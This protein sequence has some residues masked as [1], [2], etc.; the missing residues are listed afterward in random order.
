MGLGAYLFFGSRDKAGIVVPAVKEKRAEEISN[1]SSDWSIE[2]LSLRT[3]QSKITI[4]R[5]TRETA[6]FNSYVV[7]FDSDGLKQFA[8]MNVPKSGKPDGGF[9]VVVVNH[10]YIPPEEFSVEN[11]YINTSA[12]YANNGFLVLKPDYR[13]HDNSEGTATGLR[14]RI[15]YSIDV[16]N[17]IAG[18]KSLENADFENIF[19]FGHSMGGEVS[20]RVGEICGTCIR[21]ISFWAPAVTSWPESSFYFS[22]RNDSARFERLQNEFR[23]NFS[24]AD[25]ATVSTWENINRLKVPVIVHH[26][27]ADESVPYSWGV[28]LDK[29]FKSEGVSSSLYTYQNDNHDIAANW[30]RALNRDIEFF[31]RT[32]E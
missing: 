1:K 24:E 16:L 3:Y 10:G 20:L 23:E 19:M 28:E 8:L 31:R 4:E 32:I 5:K 18:I 12:Y 29:K 15:S 26:G 13:G 21:A 14:D 7:S 9:P 30:S 2:K 17:L 6:L 27:T 11:S 25:V 22:R